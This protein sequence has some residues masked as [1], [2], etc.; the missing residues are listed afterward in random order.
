MNYGFG[1]PG[2]EE[3]WQANWEAEE[4]ARV[5]EEAEQWMRKYEKYLEDDPVI[6]F[7][8][9]IFVFS[10]LAGHWAEKEHPTVQKVIEK[11]G[12]YRSK[13]SGL[14]NYLV[15]NPGYAGQSRSLLLWNSS[16]S[17][18]IRLF[19]LRI[20]KRPLKAKQPLRRLPLHPRQKLLQRRRHLLSPLQP[21]QQRS[22][23]ARH[24]RLQLKRQL[25]PRCQ[26]TT[27]KLTTLIPSRH[28]TE[29]QK[30][31]FFL[32]VFRHW[33]GRFLSNDDITSVVIPEGVETI[34]DGAFWMC[35]I[36]R[37]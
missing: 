5:E 3:E 11:G 17:K 27:A 2:E 34:E 37:A 33:R 19:C 16:R 30:L 12:Q 23:V 10:G 8:G 18:N 32:T 9:S 13:V 29:A 4:A 15:V 24:L 21:R 26:R 22:Q 14:T 7:N 36:S 6:D 1:W 20:W 28:I 31:L 35:G 25:G